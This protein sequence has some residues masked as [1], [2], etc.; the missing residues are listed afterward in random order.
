M[1]RIETVEFKHFK[2]VIDRAV[3]I[4]M[5]VV[6][7]LFI[8]SMSHL[9]I[10]NEDFP[11]AVKRFFWMFALLAVLGLAGG[12]KFRD[13]SGKF[14][15]GDNSFEIK[16]FMA[17]TELYYSDIVEVRREVYE[18]TV[19][20]SWLIPHQLKGSQ[21]NLNQYSIYTKSGK[22]YTFRVSENEERCYNK[23]IKKLLKKIYGM[24][25]LGFHLNTKKVNARFNEENDAR[26][27]REK[28]D[29]DYS[30]EKAIRKLLE[31]GNIELNDTT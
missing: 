4:I 30:L 6:I 7:V 18:K 21:F 25:S 24:N 17:N 27:D 16:S 5:A 2:P 19:E 13:M 10:N 15:F 9:D 8:F 31:K 12:R 1:N 22:K 28:P 29:T 26:F 14:I 23:K 11:I 3:I 20:S